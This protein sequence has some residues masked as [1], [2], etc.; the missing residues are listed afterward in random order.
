MSDSS[1][2]KTAVTKVKVAKIKRNFCIICRR[3][4][5]DDNK[6]CNH[7]ISV[8]NK[9]DKLKMKEEEKNNKP[10]ALKKKVKELEAK[11]KEQAASRDQPETPKVKGCII[12]AAKPA[13]KTRAKKVVA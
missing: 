3:I 10:T 6:L 9:D 5:K 4:T 11:V 2:E 1:V 13:A 12:E 8:K 7:C